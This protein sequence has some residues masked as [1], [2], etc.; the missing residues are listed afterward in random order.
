MLSHG[1]AAQRQTRAGYV[2]EI[3]REPEVLPMARPLLTIV[4]KREGL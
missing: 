3:L 2:R 1:P 4:H